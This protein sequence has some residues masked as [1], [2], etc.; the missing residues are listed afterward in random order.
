[1]IGRFNI[2]KDKGN[3]SQTVMLCC[4]GYVDCDVDCKTQKEK[5]EG[6]NHLFI[7]DNCNQTSIIVCTKV[8]WFGTTHNGG[9]ALEQDGTCRNG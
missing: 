6:K 5:S 7:H 2:T 1:M 8:T 4:Y 3:I 9:I